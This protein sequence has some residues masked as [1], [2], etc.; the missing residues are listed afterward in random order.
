MNVFCRNCG[1]ELIGSPEICP[2]CGAK[3]GR[4]GWMPLTAGILNLVVGVPILLF[5]I[6][7]AGSIEPFVWWASSFYRP[8]AITGAVLITF[9]TI[10]IIGG[11][12]SLRKRVWT[13][14][15]AGSI[16]ALFATLF[17]TFLLWPAPA[18]LYLLVSVPAVVFTVLGRK[19]FA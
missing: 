18:H 14:A 6:L 13:L 1:N 5:G 8:G 10:A 11:I 9:A 15:L 19:R 4:D 17:L 7:L 3:V 2:N 16:C 12:F